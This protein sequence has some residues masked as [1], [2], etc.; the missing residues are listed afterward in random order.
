MSLLLNHPCSIGLCIVRVP[1]DRP[2]CSHHREQIAERDPGLLFRIDTYFAK[3]KTGV[4]R[5]ALKFFEAT[6]EATALLR[7]T[8]P[9]SAA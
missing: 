3:K 9:P 1:L 8:P 2:L 6:S 4:Q 5:A 7:D